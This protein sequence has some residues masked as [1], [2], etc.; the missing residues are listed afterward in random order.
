MPG[1]PEG[2]RRLFIRASIVCSVSG[3]QAKYVFVAILLVGLPMALPFVA[4]W[5]RRKPD[6]AIAAAAASSRWQWVED[7]RA[8]VHPALVD[9]YGP[10]HWWEAALMLQRLVRVTATSGALEFQCA[11][12][13]WNAF[14]D[15][16]NHCITKYAFGKPLRSS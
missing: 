2:Q 9:L 16:S 15:L 8:G 1:T 7:V 10:L 3:W 4:A 13:T 5:S 11:V 12:L 6:P 14:R